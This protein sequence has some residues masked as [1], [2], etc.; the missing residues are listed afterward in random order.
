MIL[1]RRVTLAMLLLL[2]SRQFL[3]CQSALNPAIE[4]RIDDLLKR[5]TVEEKS[6]QLAQYD[7]DSAP[8]LDLVRQGRAG[9]LFNVFGADRTNAAQRIAVEKSRLKIPLL[10]G[11]D[12]IH[13]YR[14]IFP[15]PIGSASSFDLDLIQQSERVAAKEA[16]A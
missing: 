3:F 7:G 16:T 9:S 8:N 12:V 5:M 6:G 14:T 2:C 10:F 11:L 13:G 1:I 15:V 4:S